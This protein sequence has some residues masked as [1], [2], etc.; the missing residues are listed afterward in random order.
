M[1]EARVDKHLK[2]RGS[3]IKKAKDIL[4][5]KN[6]SET[7]ERA[8]SFVVAEAKLRQTIKEMKGIRGIE[9]VYD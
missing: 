8:L 1:R 9:K 6:E 2:I 4:K 5:T 7:V 3:L